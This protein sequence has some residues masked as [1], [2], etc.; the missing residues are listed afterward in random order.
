MA[1]YDW[2]GDENR[3]PPRL[4]EFEKCLR[5]SCLKNGVLLLRGMVARA[6]GLN[7]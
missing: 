5:P 3:K 2:D 4:R 6:E 7:P 1:K